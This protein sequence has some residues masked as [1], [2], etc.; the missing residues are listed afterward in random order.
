MNEDDKTMLTQR[1]EEKKH[2]MVV[3]MNILLFFIR[4]KLVSI[5]HNIRQDNQIIW[6][7]GLV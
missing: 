1:I 4:N 6:N 7:L 5:S 2:H 3:A